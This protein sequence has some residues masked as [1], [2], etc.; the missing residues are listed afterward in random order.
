[1]PPEDLELQE[2][3]IEQILLKKEKLRDEKPIVA[4]RDGSKVFV[5]NK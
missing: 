1:L 4:Y 2:T 3:L 5:Y